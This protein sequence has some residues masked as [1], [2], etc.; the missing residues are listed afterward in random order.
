MKSNNEMDPKKLNKE[1]MTFCTQCGEALDNFCFDD[2]AGNIEKLRENRDRCRRS[3]KSHG[4]HCSKLFIAESFDPD[5][6]KDDE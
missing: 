1:E 3:G 5:L 4:H 2:D 6:L